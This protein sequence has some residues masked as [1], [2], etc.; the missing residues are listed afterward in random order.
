MN[1]NSK[2]HVWR[3]PGTAHHL[4]NT[5]PKVK[6]AG[7]S[8]ML[9]G[10]FSVARTEG[11]VRVEEKLNAPNCWD[12]LNEN[13]VQSIQNLRL[14]RRFTF[15]QDNDPKHTARVAYHFTYR[16]LCECPWVAQP[17][18]GIKPNQIFLEK[19]ENVQ[20]A[21]IQ[22]DRAWDVNRWGEECQIIAKCWW[23]KLVISYPKRLEAVKL[24][25]LSTELR[26]WI[27]MQ[28]TYSSFL[29]LINLRSCENSVFALSV[30]CVECRLMWGKK[31]KSNLKQFNIRQQ[32][33]KMWKKWR[34]MNTFAR[35]CI[36]IY[37]S[38]HNVHETCIYRMGRKINFHKKIC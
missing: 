18:P 37:I 35:H 26:V 8:L 17:E 25:Q 6:C 13:L 22:P 23:A 27:L 21:S 9:W 28:C 24:L 4:Q 3:K 30:W 33:N 1:I 36:Y 10:C 16:Q 31:K 29:F 2:H 38:L 32:H 5:N 7:S 19:P 15:Q 34:G 11:L 14:G 12:S 20:P